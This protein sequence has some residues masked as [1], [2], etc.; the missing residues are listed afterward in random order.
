MAWSGGKDGAVALWRLQQTSRF[1]VVGLLTTLTTGY[2]RIS[3]HGV[4]E[5]LLEAQAESLGLKLYPVRIPP[6]C[7]NEVYEAEMYRVVETL[8]EEG[9]EAVGFGDLF[10]EDVRAYREKMLAPTGLEPLFPIWGED[11]SKLSRFV[12]DGGFEAILTCVDPRALSPDFVGRAYDETL[13]AD[14][15]DDVDPCGE[16]GEFHTFVHNAPNFRQGI[17]TVVGERVERD[18]FF[19]ADLLP[20]NAVD[21]HAP[22]S[23]RR[24]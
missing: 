9:V 23:E 11:T 17:P 2:D 8:R 3:M 13:L 15:P 14:L 22:P 10:L 12:I 7:S 4:R 19:F 6:K 16:N 20:T 18:G 24:R 21:T 5:A 1:E